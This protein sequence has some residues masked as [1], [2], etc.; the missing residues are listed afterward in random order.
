MGARNFTFSY[1]FTTTAG[2]NRRSDVASIRKER[3]T[4][5]SDYTLAS[6]WRAPSSASRQAIET[7]VP[8]HIFYE[9]RLPSSVL[10]YS[11]P[12]I[13]ICRFFS[14]HSTDWQ[15]PGLGLGCIRIPPRLAEPR[16]PLALGTLATRRESDQAIRSHG[17][18]KSLPGP[19][20]SEIII[21]QTGWN[22]D[23][24]TLRQDL[25]CAAG[26]RN[27]WRRHFP[28]LSPPRTPYR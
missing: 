19:R 16:S 5:P 1:A 4:Q 14:V 12:T 26:A 24:P 17:K 25:P 23:N 13:S 8:Q 28:E 21:R 18:G 27:E 3:Q 15:S 9:R 6:L 11:T 2:G 7:I 22:R 20:L 10:A